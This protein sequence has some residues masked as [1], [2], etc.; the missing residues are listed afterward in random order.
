MQ[1][2]SISCGSDFPVQVNS[3]K[4]LFSLL[5]SIAAATAYGQS[6][7]A[8]QMIEQANQQIIQQAV[9]N[10]NQTP[11]Y[12]W[13]RRHGRSDKPA[14]SPKSGGYFLPHTGHNES[15]RPEGPYLLHDRRFSA[16]FKLETLYRA[17]PTG[18]DDTDPG[19]ISG[20]SILRE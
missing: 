4:I 6:D 14:F 2:T 1:S 20:T 13:P 5:L 17:N 15:R 8:Q 11:S 19:D 12:P 3:M 10:N 7:P 18:F 9:L 16:Y